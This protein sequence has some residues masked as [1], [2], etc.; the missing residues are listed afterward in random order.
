MG[1]ALREG[2]KTGFHLAHAPCHQLHDEHFAVK[3]LRFEKT[4][5]ICSFGKKKGLSL[6]KLY[7]FVSDVEEQMGLTH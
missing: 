7:F 5:T 4:E 1:C 6:N 2:Y 3:F